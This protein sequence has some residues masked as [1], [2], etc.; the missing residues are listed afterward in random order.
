VTSR[1]TL[2]GWLQAPPA[3]TGISFYDGSRWT[4]TAYPELAAQVLGA[5][6]GLRA[7]GVR[8]GDRVAIALATGPAFVQYL[9]AAMALGAVPTPIAPP[10][11]Q[12]R[13]DYAPF[14]QARLDTLQPAAVV[15]TRATFDALTA[16]GPVRIDAGDPLPTGSPDLF[17]PVAEAELAL[18]QFTSGSS[19]AP[20]GVQLRRSAIEA[21]IALIQG[22]SDRKDD[23]DTVSGWLPLHH[24][25]GLIGLLLVPVALGAEVFLMRPEHFLRRPSDWLAT[26]GRQGAEHSATPNF[27]LAHLLRRT[28]PADLAGM[29]F[30]GWKT[31]VV[32]AD[33][34]SYPTLQ[35][36]HRLLS[37]AGFAAGTLRPSYGM[38]EATLLVS[39]TGPGQA[40][41]ALVLDSA[42]FRTGATVPVIGQIRLG[43]PDE[44]RHTV[45][46]CGTP[47]TGVEID[48]LDEDDARLDEDR[49]GQLRVRSPA[50]ASGYLGAPLDAGAFSED[51]Y[52][53]G[54]L[55]FRHDGQL[56]VLGRVGDSVKVSGRF[57]IAEDVEAALAQSLRLAPESVVVALR[58]LG[59]GP[60]VLATVQH[61]P[62]VIDPVALGDLLATLGLDPERIALLRIPRAGLPV[63]TSGKPQRAQLWQRITSRPVRGELLHLGSD[64]PVPLSFEDA[65][66]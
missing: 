40:P 46:S 3:Q 49:V 53:T 35:A 45:V 62:E 15:S 51:G 21:Q 19:R 9:F 16:N 8:P 27:A 43:G 17:R 13:G 36:V 26:F 42:D 58:D 41:A 22:F 55:G 14:A 47:G 6:A 31:L 59:T 64:F 52:R 61:R 29:D 57:V 1:P 18:I 38:A 60:A 2:T 25:M 63:T 48:V 23:P 7:H 28:R 66:G 5:A 37:P 56:Y 10:G 39:S 33:R 54:D 12:G 34:V 32:G 50:L 20:K 44:P 65:P 4:R 24:D 30:S 11:H